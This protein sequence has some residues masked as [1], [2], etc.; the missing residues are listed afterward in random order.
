MLLL[1]IAAFSGGCSDLKGPRPIPPDKEQ[2]I[3][4]WKSASG[5]TIEILSNGTANLIRGAKNQKG[6]ADKLDFAAANPYGFRVYFPSDDRMEFVQQFNAARTYTIDS[7]PR[8]EGK[9]YRMVLNG[10]ALTRNQ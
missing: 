4:S 6:E 2:F 5:F 10:V 8:Q 3:G 7:L 9:V 1:L